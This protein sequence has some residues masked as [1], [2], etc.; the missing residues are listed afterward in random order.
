VSAA[1]AQPF[2]AGDR[3]QAALAGPLRPAGSGGP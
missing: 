2:V 1:D 3:Q